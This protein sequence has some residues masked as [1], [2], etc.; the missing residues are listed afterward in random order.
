MKRKSLLTVLVV[1]IILMRG[2]NLSCQQLTESKV[3]GNDNIYQ[4]DSAQLRHIYIFTNIGIL[5]VLS[6]GIG[7][8]LSSDF[9]IAIKWGGT[10]IGGGGGYG[11][12]GSGDGIGI[13]ASY[14]LPYDIF[15]NISF[16]YIPYLRL[17]LTDQ[18]SST[19]KGNFFD[20][21]VGYENILKNNVKIFWSLGL[22]LSDAKKAHMV[23]S[24]SVKIGLN[25]NIF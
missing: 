9:S 24:P 21:N 8:Q 12:P 17:S 1:V 10:C 3:N 6:F 13:K 11:L 18:G 4:S 5:E 7:Y 2:A 20:L 16:E 25:Y 15:N 22:C 23:F 19:F 14:R